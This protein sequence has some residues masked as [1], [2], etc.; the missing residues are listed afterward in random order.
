MFLTILEP[1][2]CLL[3]EKIDFLKGNL[4]TLVSFLG[5]LNIFDDESQPSKKITDF[6]LEKNYLE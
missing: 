4:C 3:S 1:Y 2:L 6:R 5:I